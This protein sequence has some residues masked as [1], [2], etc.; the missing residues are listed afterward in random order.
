LICTVLSYFQFLELT[1]VGFAIKHFKCSSSIR[2]ECNLFVR[3][4][5]TA[6]IN[7]IVRELDHSR[8]GIVGDAS[9]HICV[10]LLLERFSEARLKHCHG[11]GSY[12]MGLN[13]ITYGPH[14]LERLIPL[15]TNIYRSFRLLKISLCHTTHDY[16]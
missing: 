16:K 13:L 3:D 11:S 2:Y 4:F 9:K 7:G 10:T 14:I 5:R 15:L 1:D 6:N 8:L 12:K